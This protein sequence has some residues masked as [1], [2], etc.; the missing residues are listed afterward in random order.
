MGVQIGEDIIVGSNKNAQYYDKMEYD[1]SSL[2]TKYT[3]QGTAG[4]E[5]GTIYKLA[6]DNSYLDSFTQV[7]SEPKDGQFTYASATGVITFGGDYTATK[8]DRFVASYKIDTGDSAQTIPVTAAGQ[9]KTAYVTAM[10]LVKDVET[11]EFYQAQIQGLAQI[12][13]AWA[14][15]LS[16]DGEPASQTMDIEFV[17]KYSE[18]NLYE[19]IVWNEEDA[20]TIG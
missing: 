20:K 16:A 9:P 18:K 4:E 7:A 2:K 14:W 10:G 8:G 15:E 17:K 1:G 19:I 5:I 6:A 3:A 11:G 12:S 13:G